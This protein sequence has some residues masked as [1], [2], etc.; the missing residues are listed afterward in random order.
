VT[1]FLVPRFILALGAYLKYLIVCDIMPHHHRSKRRVHSHNRNTRGRGRGRG[2]KRWKRSNSKSRGRSRGRGGRGRWKQRG[3]HSN[4]NND[5]HYDEMVNDVNFPFK[6]SAMAREMS[7]DGTESLNARYKPGGSEYEGTGTATP[8][9]LRYLLHQ[10]YENTTTPVYGLSQHEPPDAASYEQIEEEHRPFLHELN[11]SAN[12]PRLEYKVRAEA[13]KASVIHFGQLKLLLSEI[14]FLTEFNELGTVVVYA[15]AAPGHHIA[16]LASLFPEHTFE[17]YDPCEFSTILEGHPRV[18]CHREYFTN[19]M[20]KELGEHFADDGILFI[21][22]MRTADHRLMSDE[23]N[24]QCIVRDN[25]AQKEWVQAM[26]PRKA[27]LKFRCPYPDRIAG[28]SRY[29]DGDLWLQSFNRRSGTETRLIPKEGADCS[30]SAMRSY[31]HRQYEEQLFFFNERVRKCYVFNEHYDSSFGFENNWDCWSYGYL[32]E[33]YLFYVVGIDVAETE[34]IFKKKRVIEFVHSISNALRVNVEWLRTKSNA[35]EDYLQNYDVVDH[36]HFHDLN[37]QQL[38][39]RNTAIPLPHRVRAASP[40]KRDRRKRT[41]SEMAEG[42]HR[43]SGN[44]ESLRYV[45]P[46]EREDPIGWLKRIAMAFPNPDAWTERIR[47]L[48]GDRP[49]E[50]DLDPKSEGGDDV[51]ERLFRF[52]GDAEGAGTRGAEEE[53]GGAQ[54]MDSLRALLCVNRMWAVLVLRIPTNSEGIGNDSKFEDKYPVYA[55]G[56]AAKIAT[57]LL[58]EDD[59][60]LFIF[61]VLSRGDK[62]AGA[63]DGGREESKADET[64]KVTFTVTRVVG[65]ND[66][67]VAMTDANGSFESV[68][69]RI[70]QK[71][72]AIDCNVAFV[73]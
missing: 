72:L 54:R 20:A 32:V 43:Q 34:D 50:R 4:S 36:R 51:I 9:D 25:E 55:L 71:V 60:E 48:V 61:G 7:I 64:H 16:Y 28:P 39:D 63:A 66:D 42:D 69:E 19:S 10:R 44:L 24:E 3:G 37:A 17:L 33:R 52:L 15:G 22:D 40:R 62:E 58:S 11:V 49:L 29:L 46:P 70:T 38:A 59:R 68:I 47:D 27:M 45:A 53:G 73:Q 41:Y 67:F 8:A 23:E 65:V 6:S 56:D 31:D 21:S 13:D 5:Y 18:H 1:F 2:R 26:R 35:K 14:R 30:Y 57:A 12:Y